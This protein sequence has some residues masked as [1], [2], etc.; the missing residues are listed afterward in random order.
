VCHE[1]HFLQ[2]RDQLVLPELLSAIVGGYS[3]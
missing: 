3:R 2:G 1:D